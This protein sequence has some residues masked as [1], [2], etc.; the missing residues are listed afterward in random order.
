MEITVG[1][2]FDTPY[3]QTANDRWEFVRM[4]RTHQNIFNLD[5]NSNKLLKVLCIKYSDGHMAPLGTPQFSTVKKIIRDIEDLSFTRCLKLLESYA[6][7]KSC[8]DYYNLKS[9]IKYLIRSKRA[10]N[11]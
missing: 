2:E 8:M 1:S 7:S 10:I 6:T 3:V 11:P 5:E 9:V 4:G